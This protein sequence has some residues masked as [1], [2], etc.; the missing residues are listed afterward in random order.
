VTAVDTTGAGDC[1]C[2]ALAAAL[3]R[4]DDLAAAVR[5]AVAAAAASTTGPGARGALP[6]GATVADLLDRTPPAVPV[7]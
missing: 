6:D 7:G 4:G 2:G 5:S 3:A 1:F